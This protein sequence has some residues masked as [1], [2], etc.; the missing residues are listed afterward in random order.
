MGGANSSASILPTETVAIKELI[1]PNR[2]ALTVSDSGWSLDFTMVGY[3][4]TREA[5]I[6]AM[7]L[8][9]GFLMINHRATPSSEITKDITSSFDVPPT[10]RTIEREKIAPTAI[11]PAPSIQ[12]EFLAPAAY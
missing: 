7:I 4:P 1:D 3:K 5:K 12:R 8:R 2:Y 6:F 10:P 9:A 11:I